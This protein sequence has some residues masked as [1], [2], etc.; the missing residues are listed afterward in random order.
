MIKLLEKSKKYDIILLPHKLN[1]ILAHNNGEVY[2]FYFLVKNVCSVFV[3]F[4]F[5]VQDYADSI[6]VVAMGAIHFF[7]ASLIGAH[8]LFYGLFVKNIRT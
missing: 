4:A 7:G 2:P 8:F 3:C 5:F 1:S 6:C